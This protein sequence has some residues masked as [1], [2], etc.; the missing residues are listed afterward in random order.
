MK[1]A[2][3]GVDRLIEEG[4]GDADHDGGPALAGVAIGLDAVLAAD[5]DEEPDRPDVGERELEFDGVPPG[6]LLQP[7]DGGAGGLL[8]ADRSGAAEQGLELG[9][10]VLEVIAAHQAALSCGARCLTQAHGRNSST[11]VMG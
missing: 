11:R 2:E 6:A 1:R 7:F 10:A 8:F 9:E 4:L 5:G 3:F